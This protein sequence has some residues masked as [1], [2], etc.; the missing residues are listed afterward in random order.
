MFRLFDSFLERSRVCF[1]LERVARSNSSIPPYRLVRPLRKTI[2]SQTN[3]TRTDEIAS[4]N[5]PISSFHD[6]FINLYAGLFRLLLG[7]KS[8]LT[9][10]PLELA[11]RRGDD[12]SFTRH[13]PCQ[14]AFP[15]AR[16]R[17]R[18]R[19]LSPSAEA[20]DRCP[21]IIEGPAEFSPS[22]GDRPS[23]SLSVSVSHRPMLVASPLLFVFAF[24]K[25]CLLAI[26]RVA[27][28]NEHRIRFET[29]V[30]QARVCWINETVI[31]SVID[32]QCL[33]NPF[34]CFRENLRSVRK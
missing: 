23:I 19:R 15:R 22:D 5:R 3:P 16:R 1:F 6:P 25:S 14:T 30:S 10:Q 29:L 17:R 28:A 4:S 7:S 2:S 27:P 32:R 8:R 33:W 11:G 13:I 9:P 26:K 20:A 31:D 34:S 24:E 12:V 18:G 21:R